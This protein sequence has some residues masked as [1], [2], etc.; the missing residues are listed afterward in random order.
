MKLLHHKYFFR[1]GFTLVEL[2]I[3]IAILAILTTIG[4][5]AFGSFF[6]NYRDQQ[7]M[8]DLTTIKQALELYR[9]DQGSYPTV[10]SSLSGGTK[11]YLDPTPGDVI[12]GRTYAY[13]PTNTDST[14]CTTAQCPKYAIC[15]SREGTSGFNLPS[16]CNVSCGTLT[17]S[18]GLSSD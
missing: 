3:V 14:N 16:E 11:K 4:I 5:V 12:V 1:G 7:R 10:L 15:A 18:M 2:L 8:K 13:V 6:K 9:S 17:C